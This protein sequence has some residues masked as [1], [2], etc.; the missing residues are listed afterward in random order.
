MGI[1][2]N[3]T[4]RAAKWRQKCSWGEI[5]QR[6]ARQG[7]NTNHVRVSPNVQK[8]PEVDEDSGT[9]SDNRE[10]TIHLG[11]PGTCHKDTG[12]NQP[13]PPLGSER[14]TGWSATAG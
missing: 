4:A 9:N 7:A 5:R 6:K 13:S 2:I 11:A 8:V 1:R 14:S 3:P 10:H 12:S